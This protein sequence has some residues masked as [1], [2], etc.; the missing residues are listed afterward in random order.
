[1]ALRLAG[2]EIGIQEG[3]D[4]LDYQPLLQDSGD[5]E[6]A[7]NTITVTAKPETPDYTHSFTLAM[8]SD[9]RMALENVGVRLAIHIDSINSPAT[10]LNYDV[11][12]NG[13]SRISGSFTATGDNLDGVNLEGTAI[14]FDGSYEVKVCL[15][16]DAN[17]AGG[18]TVSLVEA[19]LAVGVYGTDVREILS[20]THWG[21]AQLGKHSP[22]VVGSGAVN[23][24]LF[25]KPGEEA[26]LGEY[27]IDWNQKLVLLAGKH[28]I[29]LYGTVDTDLLYIRA[30]PVMLRR[31][32]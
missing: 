10:M 26:G 31:L 23:G 25:L 11:E 20:I 27:Q 30:F 8:P 13:V 3:A 9:A 24:F 19:W 22:L 4:F 5:L 1:M 32:E 29:S 2:E 28:Y 6:E 17:G 7:T 16:V 21:L 15:W 12:I 18:A 14:A